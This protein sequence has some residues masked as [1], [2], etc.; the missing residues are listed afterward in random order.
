[1][2]LRKNIIF[3]FQFATVGLALAFLVLY[4]YP[5]LIGTRP[6]VVQLK[7]S[8]EPVTNTPPG[9]H[10]TSYATAVDKAAPAVVD[11]YAAR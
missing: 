3:L 8:S 7:E 11:I 9:E 6:T 10:M 1:M 2:Q 5:E 4:F